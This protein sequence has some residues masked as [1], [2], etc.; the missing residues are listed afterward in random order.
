MRGR[1]RPRP[2]RV[3]GHR[4]SPTRG[5]RR[6][7]PS[8][9]A[10]W[11][12]WRRRAPAWRR[13]RQRTAAA[14]GRGWAASA[15]TSMASGQVRGTGAGGRV[16]ASFLHAHWAPACAWGA[17]RRSCRSA[18]AALTRRARRSPQTRAARRAGVRPQHAPHP[19]GRPRGHVGVQQA[20]LGHQEPRHGPRAFRPPRQ[21]RAPLGRAAAAARPS[22]SAGVAALTTPARLLPRPLNSFYNLFDSDA[23]VGLRVGLNISGRC[24]AAG[25][26]LGACAL[27]LQP[28]DSSTHPNVAPNPAP[29]PPGGLPTCG[30]WAA[31]RTRSQCGPP[32]WARR[33]RAEGRGAGMQGRRGKG[34]DPLAPVHGPRHPHAPARAP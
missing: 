14:A 29:M 21:V 15:G 7:P 1:A 18:T 16:Q 24:G 28:T 31:P 30:R 19:R 25:V 10:C 5:P 6:R 34:L 13:M 3:R 4:R 17:R 9:T 22:C 20:V 11:P 12:S 8:R 23:D 2:P 33:A 26:G 27:D 32:R